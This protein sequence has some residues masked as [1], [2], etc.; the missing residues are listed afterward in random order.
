MRE[1]TDEDRTFGT[2]YFTKADMPPNDTL[3]QALAAHHQRGYDEGYQA[4][5]AQA[6]TKLDAKPDT[7]IPGL[8]HVPG[9]PELTTN[10]LLS[11]AARAAIEGKT[12]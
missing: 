5:V 10:Q 6:A 11:V 3:V 2:A 8:W 12:P 1:V 7:R 4:A 9:Y